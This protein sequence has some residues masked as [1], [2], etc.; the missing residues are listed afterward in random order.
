MGI[1]KILKKQIIITLAAQI[2]VCRYSGVNQGCQ[3]VSDLSLSK[4]A[5]SSA[6]VPSKKKLQR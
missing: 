6:T 2:L 3:S 4:E 1:C 5:G